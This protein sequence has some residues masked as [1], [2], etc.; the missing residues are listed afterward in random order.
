[1]NPI[2]WELLT[3]KNVVVLTGFLRGHPPVTKKPGLLYPEQNKTLYRLY[4][5]NSIPRIQLRTSI[6][7]RQLSHPF[8]WGELCFRDGNLRY[9]SWEHIQQIAGKKG[10]HTHL[11]LCVLEGG[12]SYQQNK[13][14]IALQNPNNAL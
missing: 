8:C 7:L 13:W 5:F 6:F 4:K 1:M 2:L 12:S 3:L 10:K 9:S 11:Q 14:V